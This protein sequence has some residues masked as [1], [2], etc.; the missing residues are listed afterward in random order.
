VR[1]TASH[2]STG[3]DT[4]WCGHGHLLPAQVCIDQK[5]VLDAKAFL[6]NLDHYT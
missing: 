3:R 2:V 6:P 4:R 5:G 1:A